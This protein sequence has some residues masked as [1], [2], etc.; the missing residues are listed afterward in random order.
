M[1]A[2]SGAPLITA[3]TPWVPHPSTLQALLPFSPPAV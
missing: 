3:P 1:A 2:P